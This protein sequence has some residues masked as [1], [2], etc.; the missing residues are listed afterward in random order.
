[1]LS[2]YASANTTEQRQ[3][4]YE[5]RKKLKPDKRVYDFNEEVNKTVSFISSYIK[6]KGYPPSIRNISD[7]L[8]LRSSATTAKILNKCVIAGLIEVDPKIPRAIRVTTEGKKCRTKRP[9]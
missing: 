6:E 5:R 4:T 8:D 7:A 3:R 2:S 9:R 1:M